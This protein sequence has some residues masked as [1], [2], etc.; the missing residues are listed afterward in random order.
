MKHHF[1]ASSNPLARRVCAAAMAAVM[2]LA[3]APA[4]AEQITVAGV[5]IESS[6]SL[7]GKDLVLNGAGIRYKG[8]FKVYTAA[9]YTSKLVRTGRA[10]LA[11]PGPKRMILTMLREVESGQMGR[12]FIEGVQKNLDPSAMLKVM[13]DLPRM[14]QIFAAHKKL[15][16]GDQLVI[17]WTPGVGTQISVRGVLEGPV[18]E[19]PAFNAALM[20]VWLGSS[21]ADWRL[22]DSLLGLDAYQESDRR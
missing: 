11:D 14:G 22:K 9:L 17:D 16:E 20:S 18:F 15:A 4:H 19:G 5:L 6:V 1:L 3:V 8:P 12:L 7:G 10:A 21:P 2:S 13:K